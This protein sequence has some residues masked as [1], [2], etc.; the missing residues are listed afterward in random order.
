MSLEAAIQT[1]KAVGDPTRLRLLA[2]LGAG[3]ATVGELQQIL[4]QSQPRVSRHLKLLD[5]A[6]LVTKF[7]DGQLT[8]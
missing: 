8:V 3:E 2:L 4:D 7:R 5:A 1:V 6:G